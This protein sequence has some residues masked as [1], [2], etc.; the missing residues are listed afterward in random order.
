MICA[1]YGYLRS[2]IG[3][4]D[5][6]I[7]FQ[8]TFYH[9]KAFHVKV[10]PHFPAAAPAFLRFVPCSYAFFVGYDDISI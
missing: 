9:G 8:F 6:P 1:H 10:F 7:Y 2:K 5:E 3:E 4:R